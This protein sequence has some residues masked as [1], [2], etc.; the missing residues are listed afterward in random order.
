MGSHVIAVVEAQ[1]HLDPKIV[2]VM[3]DMAH[4][5]AG[6]EIGRIAVKQHLE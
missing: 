4:P 3:A 1:L 6:A 2:E 5:D